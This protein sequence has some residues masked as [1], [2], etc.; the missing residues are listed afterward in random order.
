MM[1]LHTILAFFLIYVLVG[2]NQGL[3][4]HSSNEPP[5]HSIAK[6]WDRYSPTSPNYNRKILGDLIRE[7]RKQKRRLR[8]YIP[9]VIEDKIKPPVEYYLDP[10]RIL[11]KDKSRL[12]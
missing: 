1:K 12:A 5:E 10:P 3:C 8:Q 9:P 7:L 6:P 11:Q 4:N 2:S